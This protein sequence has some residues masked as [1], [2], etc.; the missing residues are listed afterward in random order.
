MSAAFQRRRVFP[1]SRKVPEVAFGLA[2]ALL[3]LFLTW[4][5]GREE[6]GWLQWEM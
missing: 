4:F 2:E 1:E 6:L 3:H 5:L